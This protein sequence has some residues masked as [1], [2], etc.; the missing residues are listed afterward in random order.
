MKL[1]TFAHFGSM[2]TVQWEYLKILKNKAKIL[3]GTIYHTVSE[4]AE[5]T[6]LSFRT[7]L[8]VGTCILNLCAKKGEKIKSKQSSNLSILFLY[9]VEDFFSFSFYSHSSVYQ[10]AECQSHLH[11]IH[12]NLAW[13]SCN[14]SCSF[15][16]LT[17]LP[18]SLFCSASCLSAR[19]VLLYSCSSFS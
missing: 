8:E 9:N 3:T 4:C 6:T 1:T 7:I 15:F 10:N 18:Y 14:F 19:P 13:S 2:R 12:S 16:S 11:Y 5:N 17:C